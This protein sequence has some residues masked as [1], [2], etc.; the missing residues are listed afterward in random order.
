MIKKIFSKNVELSS[1]RIFGGLCIFLYICLLIG[2]FIGLQI[3][4][5]QQSLMNN[6]LYV[7]GGLLGAGVLER[8][9]TTVNDNPNN[10]SES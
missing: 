4:L 10:M 5:T 3:S 7:G 9:G 6:L 2:S 8:F 1:K